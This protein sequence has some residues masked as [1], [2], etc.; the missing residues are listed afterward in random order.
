[1]PYN[2]RLPNGYIVEGIPDD[3]SQADARKQILQSFPELGATEKRTWGEAFTD[4]GASLAKGV[5]QLAQVPGQLGTVLG[6]SDPSRQDVGLQGLGQQLEQFGEAQKSTTLKGKEAIRGRKMAEAEDRGM[7][8]EFGTAIKETAKDPALLTSFFAEQVPNL[9][10]SWGGGMLAKGTTKALMMNATKEA[11]EQ[12]LPKAA[13]R[14]AIGTGAIQQ[15]ADVGYDTYQ[16]IYKQL[17][18]QGMADEEATGIALSKA[19]VAALEAAGLSLAA[20]KLPGGASI[21][22]ALVGKGLP[23]T[24]GFLRGMAG[25]ALS[26]GIEE[27][28]GAFAKNIGVQEVFPETSLTRGVGSAAG[29][30]A[31]GGA[32]FGGPAGALNA[33]S[34]SQRVEGLKVIKQKEQDA[35]DAID[36]TMQAEDQARRDAFAAEQAEINLRAVME[37]GSI[38]DSKAFAELEKEV[39]AAK[40]KAEAAAAKVRAAR[41]KE[42]AKKAEFSAFAQSEPDLFGMMY[43]EMKQ[44]LDAARAQ[45]EEAQAGQMELPLTDE[46]GQM[47]LPGIGI[48]QQRAVE[49]EPEVTGRPITEEDFK[50]MGIGRTNKNLREAILGKDLADPQQAAMVREALEAYAGDK[51]RSENIIKGVTTFLGQPEF[52]EQMKFGLRRPY[53]SMK[54]PVPAEETQDVGQ[55][56]GDVAGVSEPSVRVPSKQTRAARAVEEPTP[57]GMVTP[58]SAFEQPARRE[59]PID[60]AL[61]PTPE[62]DIAEQKRLMR[63]RTDAE[64]EVRRAQTSE[65]TRKAQE[66]LDKVRAELDA[67]SQ[68]AN[69]RADKRIQ[70]L[71][72]GS[73]ARQ[74]RYEEFTAELDAK[75]AKPPAK[76]FDEAAASYIEKTNT[77]EEALKWLAGDLYAKENLKL[78]N[79]FYKGLDAKQRAVVDAQIQEFKEQERRT[80]VETKR[81]D[82]QKGIR[83]TTT[84]M[85]G[86]GELRAKLLDLGEQRLDL[87]DEIAK[88]EAEGDTKAVSK[89]RNKLR[90]LEQRIS[91]LEKDLPK[92]QRA[93]VMGGVTPK[94]IVAVFRGNVSEALNVIATDT[95]GAYTDLDKE[96]AKRLNATAGRLPN[97]KVVSRE[98]L[99][100][101]DGQYDPAT[102]TVSLVNGAIDSHTF[103]H[104]TL[105]GFLHAYITDFESGDIQVS[106]GLSDLQDVYNHVLEVA[107]ELANEYGMGSLTEFSAEVMSNRDFQ[108]KLNAIPYKR[109]NA[110]VEFARAVLRILG[111]DP[112]NQSTALAVALISAERS[113][114]TG[115]QYQQNLPSIVAARKGM[116]KV[117]R[118]DQLFEQAGGKFNEPTS[119]GPFQAITEVTSADAKSK[120]KDFLNSAETMWLSSDAALNNA[121]RSE[122][123]K[124]GTEWEAIKEMMFQVSTSQA[125]HADAVA[126]QFLEKGDVVYD[127][128]T[129]KFM[130][131]DDQKNSWQGLI[132]QLSGIA[133]KYDI[134]FDKASAFARKALEAKRLQ[135]LKK[136]KSDAYIHLTDEQIAAGLELYN[137]FPEFND[138]QNTWNNIRKNAMRVAVDAGLYTEEQAKELLDFMDYVPFYRVEQLM[139]NA[140]PKEYSRGLLDFAKNYKFKGSEQEVEDL[141]DNMERWTSYTVSRAVK[142]R[143]ALNMKN[144]AQQLMPDDVRAMRQDE[145]VKK[146]QNTI[147]IWENGAKQKY[148]FKDPLFVYAFQ[149]AQPVSIPIL[150]AMASVANI[151]RKNIVLNPLFSVSQLS[152]DSIGAMFTSGLKQPFKLPLEVVKEFTKTLRGTSEAA[153]ELSR[154][155]AVG[156]RD[157][158]AAIA[159]NEVEIASGLKSPTK[160][161]KILAPLEKIAMASDNAVRQAV[162]NLTLAEGGD[163]ATAVEKAFEIINFKRGGASATVTALRQ[164]VPFY[165]A[166]LQAQNVALKTL[167][168]KG[169]SPVQ[170]REAQS[171]LLKTTA[172]V[173]TLGFIY[174]ALCADDEEYQQM[175]PSIRDRHLLIPGTGFM[176]PLRSDVFLLPK[177]TAEYVY[178]GITD[179][180]FTDAKKMRRGMK[181]AVMNAILSPTVVPQAAKPILEVMTNYSFFTGRPLI[182]QGLEN[183]VTAEQFTNTTSELAKFLG[184]AGLLSPI[185][186]DHLIRGYTGTTGGMGLVIINSATNVVNDTPRPEKSM[187]DFLATTPGLSAFVAREYGS[188]IKNDYYELRK[189]VDKSVNTYNNMRKTG[190]TE[191]AREFYEDKKE[192][193]SVKSQVNAIER[194]LTKL[195]NQEKLIYAAPASKMSAEEKGEAIER[196]R[197]TEQRMLKN[198]GELRARAGF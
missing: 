131:K 61:E 80:D 33:R 123:E 59:V 151:L 20:T 71:L 26:E 53:G 129:Y 150:K 38:T 97:I 90:T 1:M 136:S 46:Q 175:D 173:M 86:K 69:P 189:E 165:G 96:I 152:Q 101:A 177:L 127:P 168:G 120:V 194:Q 12:T 50:A 30:G 170:R 126:M 74:K 82:I 172:K 106:K 149:G 130:A 21:E 124:N 9:L 179:Q 28:G 176:L 15:G 22:R 182:G 13:L 42:D 83:K 110:F 100:D 185:T 198:V 135:G 35:L 39:Q 139:A 25:E 113:L 24:G 19:R 7:F 67:F 3:V 87:Q 88:A 79:R 154:Y 142:N 190:R 16:T 188:G 2:V 133:Q 17:I 81:L 91:A 65:E 196:I 156:V 43:P 159:R 132:K 128:E 119:K 47:G 191:E 51:N 144:I 166:Y 145:S 78:A 169:I 4:V 195:R 85:Q 49:A 54:K 155:G 157:Y 52:Q 93:D 60:T 107:P 8:A 114:S 105:H 147:D 192:L 5:G 10:G 72:A 111:I 183:R 64:R 89:G 23:G 118:A 115:R 181:D 186:I 148:E 58:V 14:G 134:P 197:Q 146:E 108:E 31:L 160:F 104:E 137:E 121:I 56:D 141:F 75:K 174:A 178:Q 48:A 63:K 102:D 37:R 158:S 6:V 117:S 62:Q 161:Q 143:T 171:T 11:L 184:K 187:Q 18:D 27:G 77:P 116:P 55:V 153:A 163:K 112:N 125:I 84:E 70:E 66:K 41:D 45:Q 138:L 68:E 34:E 164:I 73:E 40:D 98:Q 57:E 36:R 180:G 76:G 92:V 162:Y 193:F 140:G 99:P 29:L 94:L 44:Q 95:S 32:L 122:L 167:M 109:G 103:L